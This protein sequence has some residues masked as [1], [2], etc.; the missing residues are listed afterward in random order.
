MKKIINNKGFTLIE[1]LVSL[2]VIAILTVIF[3]ANYRG[4]RQGVDL[5][6]VAQKVASDIRTAQNNSLGSVLYGGSLP[7]GGWGV[8][9]D[10]ADKSYLLFADVNNNKVYDDNEAL[11][12]SGGLNFAFP[13][14][15]TISD[16]TGDSLSGNNSHA[17]LDVTF[18][19]PNPTTRIYWDQTASSGYA[20]ITLK[21]KADYK[22]ADVVINIL[23]LIDAR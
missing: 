3:L 13:A 17:K 14:D 2:S 19:P 20:V 8:H 12:T 22:T 1:I 10:T 7:A 18:L 5:N 23:G 15:L 4:G 6:L 9:F 11:P 16:I 21:H